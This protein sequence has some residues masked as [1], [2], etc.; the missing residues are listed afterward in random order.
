MIIEVERVEQLPL[1]A[2]A[3]THHDDALPSIAGFQDA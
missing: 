1:I 3:M 2:A